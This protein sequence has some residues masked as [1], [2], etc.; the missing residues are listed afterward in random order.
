M[1][2][3]L[4]IG[5]KQAKVVQGIPKKDSV[6]VTQAFAVKIPNELSIGSP[7]TQVTG[8]ITIL[9]PAVKNNN[10]PLAQECS[11]TVSDDKFLIRDVVT[12][13]GNYDEIKGMA[14]QELI[15]T[16]NINPGNVTEIKI[17]GDAEEDKVN[18]RAASLD[19]AVVDAY[20]DMTRNI[21]MVPKSLNYHSNSII[22]LLAKWPQINGISLTNKGFMLIDCGMFSCIP[23][24]FGDNA[25]RVSRYL[26]VGFTDLYYHMQKR[27]AMSD[28]TDA[29]AKT[30]EPVFDQSSEEYQAM[31]KNIV[32][33]IE[34]F[35]RRFT[36]EL[37]KLIRTIP[38]TAS[39]ERVDN[40]FLYG[41][42][43]KIQGLDQRL[44]EILGVQTSVITSVSN[45]EMKQNSDELVYFLNAIAALLNQ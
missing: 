18:V 5:T 31:P 40:I 7:A 1:P 28:F 11:I 8:M 15:A 2:I 44:T 27:S 33:Q 6:T 42:N 4:D 34:S 17:L 9:N 23:H 24:I 21:K 16:Y 36:D 10:V 13:K 38:P 30:Y 20:L 45:I 14:T 22:K 41:G 29:V 32:D 35:L 37:T 3:S 26:P 19:R 39:G 25:H 12:P 43:S